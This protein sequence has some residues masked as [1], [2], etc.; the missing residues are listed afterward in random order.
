MKPAAEH[1]HGSLKRG[2]VWILVLMM[3]LT[4]AS[5]LASGNQAKSTTV[6]SGTVTL[7]GG[8]TVDS[9]DVLVIQPGTTVRIAPSERILSLIH[10]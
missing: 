10:I 6:W 3:L 2:C 1:M 9:N 4:P 5:N 7:T 8:F